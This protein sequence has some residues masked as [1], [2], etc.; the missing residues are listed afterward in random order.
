LPSSGRLRRSRQL[1]Q[2]RIASLRVQPERHPL[3]DDSILTAF[4]DAI[5]SVFG[6]SFYPMRVKALIAIWGIVT[7]LAPRPLAIRLISMRYSIN[8]RGRAGQRRTGSIR[9]R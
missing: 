5:R 1:L 3:P 2:L 4:S 6:S 8:S 7:L 9:G